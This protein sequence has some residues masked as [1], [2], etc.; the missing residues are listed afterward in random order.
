MKEGLQKWRPFFIVR[1]R[2]ISS[3]L[4]IQIKQRNEFDETLS[5]TI[6]KI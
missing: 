5:L 3:M 1:L 2:Y 6:Y 4:I